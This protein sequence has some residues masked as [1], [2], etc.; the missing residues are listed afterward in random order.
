MREIKVRAF[1]RNTEE[2]Y[3]S[4][5]EYEDHFFEFKNG[6][7]TCF[8]ITE[9]PGTIHEPPHPEAYECED[10][11]QFTGMKDKNGKEAYKSDFFKAASQHIYEIVFEDG[12]FGYHG[13]INGDF[14]PLKHLI[15]NGIEWEIIGNIDE[16]RGY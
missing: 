13:P 12:A 2:W 3:Y 11:E 15:D 16:G 7:L 14:V 6:I 8:G 10:V 1:D 4:D 5:K 9:N